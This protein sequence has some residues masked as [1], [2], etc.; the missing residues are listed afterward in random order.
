M[1]TPCEAAALSRAVGLSPHPQTLRNPGAQTGAPVDGSAVCPYTTAW[2]QQPAAAGRCCGNP[3]L[4]LRVLQPPFNRILQTTFF[5]FFL[6]QPI[7]EGFAAASYEGLCHDDTVI[8]LCHTFVV[9]PPFTRILCHPFVSFPSSH[10]GLVTSIHPSWLCSRPALQDESLMPT[11]P[12]L[13]YT[14]DSIP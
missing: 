12:R 3:L 2:T 11:S 4:C 13:I 6:G 8:P 7:P 1:R 14:P 10:K 9:S 5:P